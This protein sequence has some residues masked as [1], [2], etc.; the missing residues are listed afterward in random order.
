MSCLAGKPRFLGSRRGLVL[1]AGLLFLSG[2][3]SSM[4]D[5]DRRAARPV[6]QAVPPPAPAM[7]LAPV[8]DTR[9]P[10]G[11]AQAKAADSPDDDQNR[12]LTPEQKAKVI[13][14]LEA[15]AARQGAPSAPSIDCSDLSEAARK[16]KLASGYVCK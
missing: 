4:G 11:A 5:F 1:L 2:C 16:A 15:L 10:A 14:E 7:P 8:P 13:A 3:M 12:L 6:A 9:L